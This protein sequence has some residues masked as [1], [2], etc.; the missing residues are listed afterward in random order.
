MDEKSNFTSVLHE[1]GL[2]R[3]LESMPDGIVLVDSAGQIVHANSH[4]EM[5]FGY[6]AGDLCGRLIETLVPERLR[7]AHGGHRTN[8]TNRPHA[9]A[10][11]AGLE[12]YGLRNDGTEFPVEISLSPLPTAKG[13]LVVSAI[14]DI[15]NRKKAERK[16][17]DLLEAAP[18]A[19]VI[20]NQ[21]GDIVIVNTQAER[22]FGYRREELVGKKIEVLIPRRFCGQHPGHRH[23][24]S[25]SP[26]VRPMGAGLELYGLRKDGT[27]FPV[28]ISLSPLE[29]ED[30]TL[31]SSAIRDITERK[32]FERELQKQNAALEAALGELESFSYSISHDLRTPLRALGGYAN[33]LATEH[34]AVLPPDARHAVERIH[35]NAARMGQLVDGLLDFSRLSRH[36]LTK[37][38]VAPA[39]IARELLEEL[40]PEMRGRAVNVTIQDLPPCDADPTLLRQVFA[41]LLGNAIKYTRGRDP[42]QIEIGWQPE[43]GSGAYLVRD[44]GAGF[45]MKYASKLFQVFQRL[46]TPEQF[47]GSGIGLA[48]VQRIIQRHGGRIWAEAEVDRGAV[49]FF[50]IGETDPKANA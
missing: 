32:N 19:I 35:S 3:L 14:R 46:H 31:V 15:T 24:Y 10:M 8:Y 44:N 41:N 20:A 39:E 49:F 43:N 26:K 47:E 42:A 37:S 11:G 33:I 6:P 45:S 13:M 18:D 16:F 12:L 22:L 30:G 25:Q 4:A 50:T 27:E 29:T 2:S 34:G 9:R 36:P 38:R 23:K 28:E 40:R 48:M 7:G 17:R 1:A 21:H 5:L